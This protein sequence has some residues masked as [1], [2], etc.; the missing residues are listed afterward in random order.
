MK[1]KKF[2]TFSEQIDILKKRGLGFGSE[3]TA[4]KALQRYGYY[5]IVNGYKDPYIDENSPEEVYRPGST[6]EQIYSLYTLDRNIRNYMLAA[7]LEVEDTLRTAVAHTVAEAFTSDQTVYLN[8][9]N[10]NL[11]KMRS[12]GKYQLEEILNKFDKIAHDEIQPMKHYR[13]TYGNLPPWILLKGASFGNI[14]NF[15]KLQK[16][17]QK[18]RIMSL[19]YEMPIDFI[20]TNEDLKSLFM[21]TL[22]VCLDYRNRAAHGGRMYNYRTH[23]T[24][25]FNPLLHPGLGV[26]EADYRHEKGHTGIDTL[27]KALSLWGNKS[28]LATLLAGVSFF[29]DRY[30]KESPSAADYVSEY[31]S[32]RFDDYFK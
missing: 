5:N 3:E 18:N 2:T 9:S 22:F 16:P 25:R 14:V 1:E 20:R 30:R 26:T 28:P 23:S 10:Y 19:V 17:P 29:M 4:V 7:M 11:G 32:A 8:P 12:S 24:F 6:F 21:D 27:A 13:E 15:I 31:I